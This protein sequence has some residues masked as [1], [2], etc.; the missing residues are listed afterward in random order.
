MSSLRFFVD[1]IGVDDSDPSNSELGDECGDEESSLERIGV[2]V[3]VPREGMPSVDPLR[4]LSSGA[5]DLASA[6]VMEVRPMGG[7]GF[8]TELT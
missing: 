3:L 7:F 4:F 2:R 8:G 5:D 1:G 6:D